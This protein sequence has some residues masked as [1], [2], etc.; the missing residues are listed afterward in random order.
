MNCFGG[1]EEFHFLQ[2]SHF[3]L[4]VARYGLPQ[5]FL[6]SQ[7]TLSLL[8]NRFPVPVIYVRDSQQSIVVLHCRKSKWMTRIESWKMITLC[9]ACRWLTSI[10]WCRLICML[11]FF[12]SLAI[13]GAVENQL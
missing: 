11:P 7:Q 12:N 9:L 13:Q 6:L 8:V 5:E 10:L 1:I 3:G 4:Y 2:N